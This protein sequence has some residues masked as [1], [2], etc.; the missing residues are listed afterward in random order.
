MPVRALFAGCG[1]LLALITAAIAATPDDPAA[2]VPLTRYRPVTSGTKT[3]RPVEPLPWGDV[4]RRIAPQL[5][6][7]PA[8]KEK[9]RMPSE[10][11]RRH[12]H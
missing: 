8:S 12:R 6:E 2:P 3:Y 9:G 4:N 7:T 11:G 5:K 1:A 10:A